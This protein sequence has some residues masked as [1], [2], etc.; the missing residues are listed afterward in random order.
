M[1]RLF[2][3]SGTPLPEQLEGTGSSPADRQRA[4]R[5]CFQAGSL[6]DGGTSEPLTGLRPASSR[7]GGRS[8]TEGQEKPL[9]E[10]RFAHALIR[11]ADHECPAAGQQPA[12]YSQ[13]PIRE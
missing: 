3:R 2:T 1:N 12:G 8:P 9:G 13:M 7:P 10:A 11:A 5:S 6:A 4:G